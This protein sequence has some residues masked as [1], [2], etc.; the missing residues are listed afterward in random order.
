MIHVPS[1]D[2]SRGFYNF[3]KV[4]LI[5]LGL[6]CPLFAQDGISFDYKNISIKSALM[7]LL[8]QH[9]IPIIFSDD[10]PDTLVS[11]SCNGCS[12][13]EAVSTIL[14][15]FSSITWKKNKSQFIVMRSLRP[16][17]FAVSGAVIDH[18]TGEPI[19]FANVFIP[20]L[21]VGDISNRDGIFS[22]PNIPVRSC[23]LAISYIGYEPCL[24]YTSP[25]PRDRQKSRM[26]SSA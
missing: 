26:P 10:T 20:S 25:S 2:L 12:D 6:L 19:P 16:Y 11:A 21:D 14:S 23:S 8:E 7:L 5:S 24:L 18:E 9:D 4:S 22:I 1:S 3:I 17:M 15:S 13:V